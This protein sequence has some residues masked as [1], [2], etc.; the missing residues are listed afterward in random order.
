LRDENAEDRA[1]LDHYLTT[2]RSVRRRLDLT[3]PVPRELILE[4]IAISEQAP[5]GSN[6]DSRWHWVVVDEPERKAVIADVYRESWAAYAGRTDPARLDDR[7]RRTLTAG[8]FVADHL[9]EVPALVIP[10]VRRHRTARGPGQTMVH[11][12]ATSVYG[13]IFPAVWSFCLALRARGVGSSLTTMHLYGADRVAELLAI[14]EGFLQ[15][16]LL[17]IGY[18]TGEEF[19]PVPRPAPEEITGFNH[20]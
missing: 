2:T 9:H 10:C 16:C 1:V 17:P 3:R 20:W 7:G 11:A 15:A 13:S 14:P 5:V 12:Y 18:Y 19:R 4:C 6:Q 8:A